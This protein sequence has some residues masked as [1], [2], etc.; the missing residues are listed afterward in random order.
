MLKRLSSTCL[1]Q[2]FDNILSCCIFTRVIQVVPVA[3]GNKRQIIIIIIIIIILSFVLFAG[4]LRSLMIVLHTFTKFWLIG[5]QCA[6]YS[7]KVVL[8]VVDN[9]VDDGSAGRDYAGEQ[10]RKP[11]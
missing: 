7:H 1:F 8:V 10:L 9:D 11:F 2:R 5:Q 4:P 3:V 6:I